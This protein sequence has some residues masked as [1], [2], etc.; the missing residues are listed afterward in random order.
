MPAT[1]ES[2]YRQEEAFQLLEEWD[3]RES[4]IPSEPAFQYALSVNISLEE[5]AIPKDTPAVERNKAIARHRWEEEGRLI[6]N[7]PRVRERSVQ[8]HNDWL[9]L[10]KRYK[11]GTTEPSQ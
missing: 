7:W 8:Q 4:L 10:K 6:K 9:L 1:L 5:L 3:H 2:N 11:A